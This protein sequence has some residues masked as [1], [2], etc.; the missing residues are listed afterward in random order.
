M[1]Y[2]AV[3]GSLLIPEPEPP[4]PYI[5]VVYDAIKRKEVLALMEQYPDTVMKYGFFTDEKADTAKLIAKS[6]PHF[7]RK[8]KE[9]TQL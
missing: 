3:I 9:S 5:A 2:P 8:L 6:V 7:E 4:P 1:L